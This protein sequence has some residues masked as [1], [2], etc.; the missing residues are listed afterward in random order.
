[1]GEKLMIITI[2]RRE[3]RK[4]INIGKIKKYLQKERR[5]I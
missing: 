2:K 3:I 4:K 5:K 1:V